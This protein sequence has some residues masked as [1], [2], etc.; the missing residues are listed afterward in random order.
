[1]EYRFCEECG[2]NITELHHVIYRSQCTYMSNIKVNF[3][4]L[5]P[6]HHRGNS[7]PHMNRDIDLKYKLELQEKLFSMFSEK[8]Y[9][10]EKEIMAKLE[11][12]KNEI[13]KITKKMFIA[14]EGYEV[15]TLVKRLMG[16]RLYG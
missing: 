14:K 9:W 2:R 11:C 6:E 15:N 7:S 1:M 4:F 5:C 8:D 12:S 13:K 16:N 10:T 3:K